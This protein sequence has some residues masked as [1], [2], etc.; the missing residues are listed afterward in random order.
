[1]NIAQEIVDS[2][3]YETMAGKFM[4]TDPTEFNQTIP[5]GPWSTKEEAEQAFKNYVNENQITFE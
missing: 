2:F 4:V 1:M 5:G 3:V